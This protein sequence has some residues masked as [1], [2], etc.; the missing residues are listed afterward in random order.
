MKSHHG[1]LLSLINNTNSI[2]IIIILN[3]VKRAFAILRITIFTFSFG[4][5]STKNV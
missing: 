5:Q 4:V 1:C 3:G 2:L